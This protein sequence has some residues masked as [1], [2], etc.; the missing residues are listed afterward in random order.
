[1][2]H[3]SLRKRSQWEIP[4]QNPGNSGNNTIGTNINGAAIVAEARKYIGT[5]YQ[6]GGKGPDVFDCSGFT[7]YGLFTS[8]QG[9][10]LAIGP[11]RK[12]VPG[13]IIPVSQAQA[14]DRSILG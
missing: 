1:M 5:P 11:F 10:I 13:T 6:W 4:Q 8:K 2:D 9:Q 7:R 14:G 3:G 12:K